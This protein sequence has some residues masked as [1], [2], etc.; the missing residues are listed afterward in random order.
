[1]E[2]NNVS[3]EPGRYVFHK[4]SNQYFLVEI[5]K[6]SDS[7]GLIVPTCQQEKDLGK[8]LQM[9]TLLTFGRIL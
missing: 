4:V 8:E 9:A 1:M 5:W 6:S 7:E 3:A 2:S